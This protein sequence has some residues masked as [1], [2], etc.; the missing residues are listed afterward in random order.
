ML[1]SFQLQSFAEE[2]RSSDTAQSIDSVA[3]TSVAANLVASRA[4]KRKT[5][6]PSTVDETKKVAFDAMNQALKKMNEE[7]NDEFKVFGDFIAAELRK[8]PNKVDANKVQRKMQRML[9]DYMDELDGNTMN[10]NVISWLND[11]KRSYE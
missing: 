6:L 11:C 7:Q 5:Q 3:S 2:T 4:I 10:D 8:I 1:F 9:L